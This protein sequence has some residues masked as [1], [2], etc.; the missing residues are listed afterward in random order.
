M[1]L[2]G[3]PFGKLRACKPPPYKEGKWDFAAKG[4]LPH[5]PKGRPQMKALLLINALSLCAM[6][7]L[8]ANEFTDHGVGA[9]VAESRGVIT[10]QDA[11][12]AS[13]VIACSLDQS[14]KGWILVTDIDTEETTQYNYPQGVPNSPPYASLMSENGRFY[15]GAGKVLLEFD[16]TSREWLFHGIPQPNAGC[17][18]GSA[19]ADG[20]DG[21]IYGGTCSNC[22][23]FSFDPETKK[24]KD[25]GQM[26]AAEHYFSYLA[27]DESGWAYCGIGTARYNIVAYDP[28]T[29]ERRQLIKEEDRK[30][31]TA[32]VY[33][34]TDGKVYGRAGDQSYRMFEGVA[35]AIE[36]AEAG[37]KAPTGEIGWGATRGVFPDRRKLR[38]FNLPDRWMEIEDPKTKEVK[39]ITFD[40]E[41]EGASI[42]SLVGGPDGK[43]YGSTCHPMHF[44]AY[45]PEQDELKDLGPVPRVGGGNFCAMATQGQYIAAPS[46]ASGS[47]Y[48]FDTKKPFNGGTGDDPNPRI[49]A[50]YHAD[51]CRPRAA[52]AHPDGRHVLM[53][54]FMGYGRRGGG[55]AIHDLETDQGTLI[56]HKH[57]IPEQS[58]IT[59]RAL[60]NGD[61]VGGTSI[62]TPGGGHPTA[63][64]GVLYIMDWNTRKV[65]FRTVPVPG[66]SEV[67]SLEVGPDGL[68]YGLAA[69]SQFFVFDPNTKEAVHREPMSEY[70]GLPRPALLRGP[71]DNIYAIFTKAI[72]RIEPG[73]FKHEKLADAPRGISAG[74]AILGGRLYFAS[75]SHLWSY[76]LA[77]R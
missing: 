47:F 27:L 42:T 15:T 59:L 17:F 62:A 69:G 24:M 30:L 8:A 55:L 49:L 73:T 48:L 58:T 77:I 45:S 32:R 21:L 76:D 41:S 5:Y 46:Y 20:P 56:T 14:P 29:G 39:R 10:T 4:L 9:P 74:L 2:G 23:L 3:V 25:Y 22:H 38:N 65:V 40:Y 57:L 37:P 68:V 72:V 70:G 63:K 66:A 51:I 31:G 26:D 16:P 34:G 11:N 60:P 7:A 35:T 6:L 36:K 18:V 64:E 44:F 28:R 53:A 50:Q 12:G 33:L 13:L 71:D 61:I 52:L 19:L 54:G 67:F 75:G 43:V 1:P